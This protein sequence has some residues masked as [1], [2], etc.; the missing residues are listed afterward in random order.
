MWCLSRGPNSRVVL[1][2]ISGA[3]QGR[4]LGRMR[5]LVHLP[6]TAISRPPMGAQCSEGLSSASSSRNPTCLFLKDSS[7]AHSPPGE[8]GALGSL[9]FLL[10]PFQIHTL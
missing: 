7:Q 5:P 8:L 9:S 2:V 10:G 1:G 4:A 3:C 6:P